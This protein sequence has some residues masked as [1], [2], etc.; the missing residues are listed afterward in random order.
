M[1]AEP[2]VTLS[3]GQAI[4][5]PKAPGGIAQVCELRRR[6][7]RI[8]YLTHRGRPRFRILPAV[9][10]AR[11]MRAMPLMFELHNPFDRGVRPQ[12]KTYGVEL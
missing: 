8:I 11:L 7:V 9:N 1:A 3:I 5:W 6:N 4:P 2:T 10:V 12:S